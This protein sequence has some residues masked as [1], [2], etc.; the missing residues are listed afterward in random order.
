[1]SKNYVSRKHP[2][3][4]K[5]PVAEAGVKPTVPLSIIS[6]LDRELSLKGHHRGQE[7]VTE[8]GGEKNAYSE[9]PWERRVELE[10][11]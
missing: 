3:R 4:G 10:G 9:V 6:L 5:L 1:M 11:R 7:M 8:G 2:L